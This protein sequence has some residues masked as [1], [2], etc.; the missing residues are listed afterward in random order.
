MIFF[1]GRVSRQRKSAQFLLLFLGGEIVRYTGGDVVKGAAMRENSLTI[2][3]IGSATPVAVH[4]V[5][6]LPVDDELVWVT[7]V[8]PRGIT[9]G[10]ARGEFTMTYPDRLHIAGPTWGF[11]RV[12]GPAI[13]QRYHNPLVPFGRRRTQGSINRYREALY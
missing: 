5:L 12:H 8:A 3:I 6:R 11:R 10:T 2:S 1:P 4:D 13:G 9:L 7:A